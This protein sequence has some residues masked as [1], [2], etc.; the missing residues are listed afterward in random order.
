MQPIFF[1]LWK[2]AVTR[3]QTLQRNVQRLTANNCSQANQKLVITSLANTQL[4]P[5]LE[6]LENLI[7]ENGYSGR[8]VITTTAFLKGDVVC[9]YHAE[10]IP[11]ETADAY[12]NE[13]D[14][15]NRKSDYLMH[16]QCD[17]GFYLDAHKEVC[18]CHPHMRTMGRLINW[19]PSTSYEC[20]IK[21]LFYKFEEIDARGV[22]FVAT[23][24]IS[25]HEQ[26]K[27]DYGD[28]TCKDIFKRL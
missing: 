28:R 20:N 1:G 25:D 8:G 26:I 5:S 12:T 24:D 7:F 19:A 10:E 13:E 11:K 15:S 14:D 4:W 2:P 21:F 9:D 6:V 22:L 23:R 18:A 27:Y 17:G 16:V 3:T